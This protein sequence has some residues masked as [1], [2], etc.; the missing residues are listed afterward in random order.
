MSNFKRGVLFEKQ[1]KKRYNRNIV[2]YHKKEEKDGKTKA[3]VKVISPKGTEYILVDVM[4]DG[5]TL[6]AFITKDNKTYKYPSYLLAEIMCAD[7]IG[8]EE[9]SGKSK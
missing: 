9:E 1:F 3:V 4:K 8:E 2:V 7:F 5:L 6:S